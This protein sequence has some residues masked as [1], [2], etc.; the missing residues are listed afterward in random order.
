MAGSVVARVLNESVEG[1]EPLGG[2]IG[3]Y[4]DVLGGKPSSKEGLTIASGGHGR[5]LR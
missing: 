2:L 3:V 5:T 4:V 1:I